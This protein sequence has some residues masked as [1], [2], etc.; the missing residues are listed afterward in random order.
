MSPWKLDTV[1]SSIG[2]KVKHLMVSTVRGEFKDFDGTVVTP[3]D[4]FENA[5]V[6]FTASVSSLTTGNDMRD[7]H[8]KSADF[9]DAEN[10]PILS[11]VSKK[12]TK[13]DEGY[14]MVGDL[15]MRGVTKEISLSVTS[16]GIGTDMEGK[17]VVGFDIEGSVNRMEYGLSWNKT[18]ETGGVVVSEKVVL[19]IHVEAKE[20][21]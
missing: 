4:N 17:R 13:K 11:F 9:F 1:H 3:D 14:E 5:K 6:D 18:L 12:I 8:L 21:K 19:D 16:D 7:G 20:V 10:S 15:T 2:F